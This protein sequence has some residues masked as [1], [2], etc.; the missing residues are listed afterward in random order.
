MWPVRKEVPS[1]LSSVGT[2]GARGEGA[3]VGTRQTHCLLHVISCILTGKHYEGTE[4][5]LEAVDSGIQSLGFH[6]EVKC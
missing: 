2:P 5:D 1:V 3:H 4:T 6:G